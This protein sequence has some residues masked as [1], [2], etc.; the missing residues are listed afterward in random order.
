MKFYGQK[1]KRRNIQDL[2]KFYHENYQGLSRGK[3]KLIDLSF[4]SMLRKESY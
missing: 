2:L 4:Y 1:R 3:L